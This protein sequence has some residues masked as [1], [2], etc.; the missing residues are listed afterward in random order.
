M[1]N[2]GK[3]NMLKKIAQFIKKELGAE[4]PWHISRFS[5]EI[6]WKLKNLSA[7]PLETLENAYQIG[8]KAGLKYVY[9]GNI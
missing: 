8:I 4:T 5:P 2:E 9:K 3:P 7:T 6:S 1:I